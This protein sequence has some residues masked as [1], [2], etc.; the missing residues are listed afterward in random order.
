[1]SYCLGPV[2]TI[3]VP[4]DWYFSCN[5]TADVG[6][7]PLNIGLKLPFTCHIAFKGTLVQ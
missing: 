6:H 4:C 3:P 2:A 1:M 5:F 7:V